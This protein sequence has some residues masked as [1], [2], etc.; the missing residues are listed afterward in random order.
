MSF[1]EDYVAEGLCCERC[2]ALIDMDEPG[3]SRLCAGCQMDDERVTRK[4]S[5]RKRKKK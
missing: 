5:Q 2:G 4:P 3:F 1:Y